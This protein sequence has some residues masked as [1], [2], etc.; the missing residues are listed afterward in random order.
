MSKEK[1]EMLNQTTVALVLA[2]LIVLWGV[3]SVR[4]GLRVCALRVGLGEGVPAQ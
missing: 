2:S 3:F 4:S 1:Q